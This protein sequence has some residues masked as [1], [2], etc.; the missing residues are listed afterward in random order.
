MSFCLQSG[1]G[2]IRK[3]LYWESVGKLGLKRDF[4]LATPDTMR[5][6]LTEISKRWVESCGP[7]Y[8]D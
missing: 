5:D 2:S 1:L 7:A 8:F 3:R 4:A 6:L